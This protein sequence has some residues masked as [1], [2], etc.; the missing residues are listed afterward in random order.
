MLEFWKKNNR[1][2]EKLVGI[3]DSLSQKLQPP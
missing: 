3:A 2:T 1:K